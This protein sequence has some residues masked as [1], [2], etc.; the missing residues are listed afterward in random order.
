P[1]ADR[2]GITQISSIDIPFNEARYERALELG[3]T[4]NR[5][6]VY[7][8]RIETTPARYDWAA[9]DELIA[10]DS[11]YGLQD[12]A[13]LL[14]IP[15]ARR[16][17]NSIDNIY[18]A[19]FRDG[20]DNP[21]PNKTIN[22]NNYWALF[23]RA[24]VERYMPGGVLAQTL[25]WDTSRGVRVWEIWNEPDFA[26]FWSAG[27]FIY[28]RLLKVAYLAIKTVDPTAVVMFGGLLYPTQNN[29]FA[30]VLNTFV[31]DPNAVANAWYMDAVGV[32]NYGDAW[33]SGWLTLFTRQT[34][35]EFGFE[36]PIWIT[37]TGVPIWDDYPGA[38]WLGAQQRARGSYATQEQQADFLIQ[39]AAYAWSEGATTILYHQLYD[40]C[41]NQPAG[42]NFPP[43][44]GD[45]CTPGDICFGDSFGMY[46]NAEDAVCFAQHP[47]PDTARPVTDAFRM[48]ADAFSGAPISPRG[49]VSDTR[50]DG[51]I[52]IEFLRPAANEWITVA[53]NT[54]E[55]PEIITIPARGSIARLFRRGE[56]RTLVA[57]AGAY[58]IDLAP[59]AMPRQRF[60]PADQRVEI[61][62]GGAPIILVESIEA[63]ASAFATNTPPGYV[64]P[65]NVT[66]VTATPAFGAPTPA[67]Q[68]SDAQIEAL[69]AESPSGVAF[70]SLNVAR[71]R[72]AP[73][74]QTGTVVG[75]MNI[76]AAANVI[77]KTAAGDWLQ[78]TDN[79]QTAWVAAFLGVVVGDLDSVPIVEI[80]APDVPTAEATAETTG[81]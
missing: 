11:E 26:Q 43:H 12:V 56:A 50:P 24:A 54:R 5:F 68:L 28:A 2:L 44:D 70:V 45:L 55:T 47:Q 75:Q 60:L 39:S 7:W 35:I 8:D 66:V 25:E 77:G 71:L 22:P 29:F 78:I 79:D 63:R 49:I 65:L 10:T 74:T 67:V 37:E 41:G 13:V 58:S 81:S 1:R 32:H 3:A 42:T 31:N 27:P 62:I 48:L 59:A 30:Q 61:D 6:P 76:G 34:M 4:W 73:S 18:E 9:Y 15:A 69:I 51:L 23:A 64:P 52:T 33:R 17:G 80:A 16:V 46:R 21:A 72:A 36:R 20:T 19:V 57:A 53:W 40:D 38:T 14:G